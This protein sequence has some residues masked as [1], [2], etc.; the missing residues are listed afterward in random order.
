MATELMEKKVLTIEELQAETALELPDRELMQVQGGLVNVAIGN[1][2]IAVPISVAATIC[3]LQVN[4]LA[5][6]LNQQ[7]KVECTTSSQAGVPI[8]ASRQ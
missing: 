3:G 5:A 8:T 6:L 2:I 1:L 4:V 7:Q